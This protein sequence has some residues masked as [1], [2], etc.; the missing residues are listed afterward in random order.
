MLKFLGFFPKIESFVCLNKV[1]KTGCLEIYFNLRYD[2]LKHT[3]NE[4]FIMQRKN[5]SLLHLGPATQKVDSAIYRHK[6]I[7]SAI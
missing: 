6:R 5:S 7:Y 2:G 4:C 1:C 3:N